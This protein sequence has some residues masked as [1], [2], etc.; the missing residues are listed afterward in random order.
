MVNLAAIQSHALILDF[1]AMARA[2]ARR[3]GAGHPQTRAAAARVLEMI[4]RHRAR[5]GACI[6]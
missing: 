3:H 1:A 5:F 2:T 4:A 6:G